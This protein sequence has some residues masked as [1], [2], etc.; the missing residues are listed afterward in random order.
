MYVENPSIGD[1]SKPGG[2]CEL[3]FAKPLKAFFKIL[4]GF[5]SERFYQSNRR[6]KRS[7]IAAGIYLQGLWHRCWAHSWGRPPAQPLSGLP[8]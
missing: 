2:L 1:C 6:K 5:F 8:L 3:I 7:C 4:G